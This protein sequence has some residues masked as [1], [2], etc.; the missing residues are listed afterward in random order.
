MIGAMMLAF[1]GSFAQKWDEWFKQKK[2]QKKYLIQQIAALK[3]YLEQLKEGYDIV[4]KGLN[5][6]GDI[7][8]GK[9]HLDEGYIASLNHVNSAVSESA[10][11]T[12]ILAYQRLIMNEFR[13]LEKFC[14]TEPLLTLD[15]AEY[16]SD[17]YR[18]VLKDCDGTLEDLRMVV[19]NDLLE[20]KDDERI[21]RLDNLYADM[22]DKYGFTRSFSNSTRLLIMQRAIETNE[23]RTFE[24]FTIK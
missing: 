8:Q 22:K 3:V 20:M 12:E 6:I 14:K 18:N 13:K 4:K 23:I 5:T 19:D 24:N 9:F 7:R 21:A 1:H 17:V 10:K 15:E 11:V 2:T 16:V